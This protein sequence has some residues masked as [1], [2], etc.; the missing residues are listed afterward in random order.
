[1]R[2][3]LITTFLALL[4]FLAPL[5]TS[6]AGA[7]EGQATRELGRR[8]YQGFAENRLELWDGI[9]SPNVVMNSSGAWD[10]HGLDALKTWARGFHTAFHPRIDL[11][12][13]I[14]AGDRLVITVNL[15]WKHDGEFFG[16][17]PTGRSGTSVEAFILT[18]RDGQVVQWNVADNTLDLAIYLWER[19]W[20]A[21]HNVDPPPII[22][23]TGAQ[24]AR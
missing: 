13:E 18:I 23:G 14:I 8:I 19:G 6:A 16:I 2:K 22:R 12:D 1:M 11:V 24:P 10:V 9:V 3:N 21:P 20:P 17:R 4:A 15:H 7:A 5:G